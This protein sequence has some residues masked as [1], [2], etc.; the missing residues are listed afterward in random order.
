MALDFPT[1]PA[2]GTIFTSGPGAWLWDGTKWVG[3]VAGVPPGL[4]D[5]DQLVWVSGAWTVQ[6]PRYVIS[7]F[8]PG[9]LTAGQILLM[10]RMPT[11]VRFPAMGAA[12][13][14]LLSMAASGVPSAGE[15][16]IAVDKAAQADLT[17]FSQIGTITFSTSS[18]VGNFSSTGVDFGQGDVLRLRAPDPADTTL[19]DVHITLVGFEN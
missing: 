7:C 12:Y 18:M 9:R 2:P 10:H 17:A 14:G 19:A 5:Y 16:V 11:A 1:A 13:L 8:V 15:S 3:A 4:H 6:E